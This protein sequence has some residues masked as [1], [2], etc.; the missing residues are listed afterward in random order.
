VSER[1][2]NRRSIL[3]GALACG[4]SAPAAAQEADKISWADLAPP[5]PPGELERQRRLQI[6]R[7]APHGSFDDTPARMADLQFGSNRTV[8]ALNGKRVRL[9][10]YVAPLDVGAGT[11]RAFLLVPYFGACIH[12]PP[13]PPNQ[14]V[15]VSSPRPVE[16]ASIYRPVEAEGV[17]RIS[18]TVSDMGAAAY[19]LTLS[20]LRRI[21]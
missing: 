11:M 13:P 6:A 5:A 21:R 1:A 12:A 2:A 15:Y 17:L 14:T 10:G 20:R 7:A 19:S 18:T 4:L 9:E 8:P 3:A 16:L